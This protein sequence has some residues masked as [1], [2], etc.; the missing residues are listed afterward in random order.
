MFGFPPPCLVPPGM[1]C[2][3]TVHEKIKLVVAKMF[4]RN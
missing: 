3:M 4:V 1:E 2:A